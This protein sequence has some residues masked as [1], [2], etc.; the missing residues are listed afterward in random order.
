VERGRNLIDSGRFRLK[1]HG[2]AGA[3]AFD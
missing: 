1:L 2:R 3:E